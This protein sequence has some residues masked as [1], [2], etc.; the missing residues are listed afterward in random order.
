MKGAK[1]APASFDPDAAAVP[2]SGVFGLSDSPERARVVL[3]PVPV[4]ATTSY[5]G[6]ASRGP[7]AILAAS[8]QVDLYDAETGRP[9]EAGIAWLQADRRVSRLDRD[10]KR[11]AKPI[12]ARGGPSGSKALQRA[13]VRISDLGARVNDAVRRIAREWIGRGKLV[14]VVGGDH[15][16]PFGAIEA[17]A[18][19]HPGLG[20]LHLDAHADLRDAYEGLTWSH[21]SIM[22]NVATRLPGVARIV[23]V[24]IRDLSGTEAAM[25]RSSGGRIRT[26]F[27]PDLQRSLL[28]GTAFSE[29]AKRIVDDLPD[30][31][32]LSFDIDGL[33]PALCPHTGTPVPGGLSFAQATYLLRAVVESGRRIVGFDLCE[34]A[35]GPRGDEWDGNVGARL[36]YKMIGWALL[37]LRRS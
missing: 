5:G 2:G 4:E 6:G 15:S 18:E 23:Q 11:L 16:A 24:G 27:D 19:R 1:K 20:I 12:V 28:G 10:A 35:P 21:A 7:A 31:V 14:G 37:S 26:W 13:A 22:H 9:Y 25:I 29:L 3:L 30:A 34:V 8:R 17:Q 32:Y 36:L 33:D